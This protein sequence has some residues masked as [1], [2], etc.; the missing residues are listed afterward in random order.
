MLRTLESLQDKLI[1]SF[2]IL[3]FKSG[4]GFYF[5]KV[6]AVIVDISRSIVLLIAISILITGR[7]VMA[8]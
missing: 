5:L 7:I 8:F 4:E 2:E 1:K 6:K 3:D